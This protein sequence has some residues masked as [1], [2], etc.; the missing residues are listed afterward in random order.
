MNFGHMLAAI[1]PKGHRSGA[2]KC[3]ENP[4]NP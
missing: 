2:C 4:L 3:I 1:S